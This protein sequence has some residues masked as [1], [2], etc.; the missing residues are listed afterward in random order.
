MTHMIH[1]SP[2]QEETRRYFT[3]T[4]ALLDPSA[5][6]A[7]LRQ[8]HGC[9]HVHPRDV[10]EMVSKGYL[11]PGSVLVIHGYDEAWSGVPG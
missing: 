7:T 6:L 4:D 10:D 11:A 3:D 9:E 8:S 2:D 1:S 5:A